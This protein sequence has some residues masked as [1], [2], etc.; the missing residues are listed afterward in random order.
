MSYETMTRQELIRAKE[1]YRPDCVYSR[2]T[3][4]LSDGMAHSILELVGYL[5]TNDT[6]SIRLL[7]TQLREDDTVEEHVVG[8]ETWFILKESH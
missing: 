6:P 4:I 3:T 7:R 1:S 2:I 8:G 5:P